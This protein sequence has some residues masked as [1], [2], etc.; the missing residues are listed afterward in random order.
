MV[1]GDLEHPGGEGVLGVVLREAREGA[2][3]GFLDDV[4]RELGPAGELEGEGID[5]GV[6]AIDQGGPGGGIAPARAFDP[7]ALGSGG[8]HDHPL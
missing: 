4:P 7:I 1:G 8:V 3:E 5:G 2:E 6:V